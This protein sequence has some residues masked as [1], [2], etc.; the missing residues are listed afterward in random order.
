MHFLFPNS[1]N[2]SCTYQGLKAKWRADKNG[3]ATY[4]RARIDDIN[5]SQSS[6]ILRQSYPF[7]EL[8]YVPTGI[9]TILLH[10]S[11]TCSHTWPPTA[12]WC[13]LLSYTS[14]T[15]NR[16]NWVPALAPTRGSSPR[17][18]LSTL[19]M[20]L[21][22]STCKYGILCQNRLWTINGWEQD[23][24]PTIQSMSRAN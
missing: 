2:S 14:K 19:E 12:N 4:S 9:G 21:L 22:F 17:H 8:Q 16:G 13:Y 5:N 3:A 7:R 18:P 6:P 15:N 23:L 10:I 11:P 1:I 24:F 20:P